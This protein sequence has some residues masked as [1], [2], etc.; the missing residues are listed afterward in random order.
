MILLW[1][2]VSAIL[3]P[4]KTLEFS[5]VFKYK[6]K[7]KNDVKR[8]EE[9]S[10]HSEGKR[11]FHLKKTCRFEAK[12]TQRFKSEVSVFCNTL[13]AFL[14]GIFTLDYSTMRNV[15]FDS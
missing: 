15:S 14:L 13:V 10:E 11:D 3:R 1:R 7:K 4:Y 12:E 9:E 5:G 8:N 6:W 2:G